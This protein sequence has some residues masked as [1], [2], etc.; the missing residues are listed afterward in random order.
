[1][2]RGISGELSFA[3][4]ARDKYRDGVGLDTRGDARPRHGLPEIVIDNRD[5]RSNPSNRLTGG[6]S[7]GVEDRPVPGKYHQLAKQGLDFRLGGNHEH[8]CGVSDP[9]FRHECAL[10]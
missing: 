4:G 2:A 8:S 6:A 1:M 10:P 9:A 5:R 7:R 3:C